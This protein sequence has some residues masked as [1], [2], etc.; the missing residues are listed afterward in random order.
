MTDF[1]KSISLKFDKSVI[2]KNWHLFYS[3]VPLNKKLECALF[4]HYLTSFN[5][6]FQ[7][8]FENINGNFN[9]E[10]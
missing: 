9:S 1:D 7:L 4:M 10:K 6:K 5:F 2:Q 3:V 8:S